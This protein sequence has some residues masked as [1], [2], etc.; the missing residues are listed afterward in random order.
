MRLGRR[1]TR[2][3]Q[4]DYRFRH[5]PRGSGGGAVA[6]A[7][8]EPDPGDAFAFDGATFPLYSVAT[9]PQALYDAGLNKTFLSW[10]AWDGARSQ[11]VTALDHGTDLFSK[12]MVM[13]VSTLVD[14]DHGVNAICL[15]HQDHLH[16]FF[17]AHN[18]ASMKH[19]STRFPWGSTSQ[20]FVA[21]TAIGSGGY[22]YP[23]PFMVGSTMHLLMR[24][25]AGGSLRLDYFKTSA[26]ADGVATWGAGVNIITFGAGGGGSN[27][28]VYAGNGVL[29]GT[30]FHFVATQDND[31]SF[32]RN[33][34]YY[35][36][37]DTTT[38]NLEN[39]D[40]STI[41]LVGDLPA[42]LTDANTNFRIFEHTGGNEGTIPG[43]AFD[44]NGDPFVVFQDGTGSSFNI[45][46]VKR[47][48]GVW[49]APETVDTS[50]SRVHLFSVGQLP[51]G[52][53]EVFYEFDSDASWTRGG[54]MMRRERSAGGAWGS[55]QLILAATTFALGVSSTIAGGQSDARA[56]FSEHLQTSDDPADGVLKVYL[57]GSNGLVPYVDAGWSPLD[58]PDLNRW[59]DPSDAT[60][61]TESGGDVSQLND[62]SGNALDL[63]QVGALVKPSIGDT[64]NGLGVITYDGNDEFLSSI[65]GMTNLTGSDKPFTLF[66]V[67]EPA[68]L[69]PA[70]QAYASFG[71]TGSTTPLTSF[72]LTSA[73]AW[74]MVKRD[75]AAASKIANGGTPT[76][77]PH[78]I[79][80]FSSGTA[81]SIRADG[82]LVANAED[83]NVGTT[84]A[85]RFSLGALYG[86]TTAQ[87]FF[88]G[89]IGEVI[90]CEGV[91]D[92]ADIAIVEAYLAAK[93]GISI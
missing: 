48:A 42:D 17:G 52:A 35:F 61:I 41:I 6:G 25:L 40:G 30:D 44:T 18:S 92:G 15:D 28:I 74:D 54:D 10:E 7:A 50:D 16:T 23:K 58:L 73:P 64:I 90:L 67:V 57:W 29:V 45:K 53:V 76:T 51:G 69:V 65:G 49:G 80:T 72:R 37:L 87:Q 19:S 36:V 3:R 60:T 91:L 2:G 13:G 66:A 38:G 9:H 70:T 27:N 34:V 77:A 32:G 5:Q 75:D 71:S 82:V 39:H 47:T 24:N 22:G 55:P 89:N 12:P 86:L 56:V 11:K 79:T 62:K 78:I 8:P 84:T 31:V 4:D 63:V 88:N 85:G 46:V 20:A 14:D 93:W 59:Y 33:N 26:L 21:R 81:G 1:P 43:L 68:T 83:I